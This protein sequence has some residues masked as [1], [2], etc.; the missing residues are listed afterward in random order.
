MITRIPLYRALFDEQEK[1]LLQSAHF[2][3]SAWV[4]PSGVLALGLENS[5]G[6]LVVLPYQGQM[7]WSAVFDGCDLTMTN[8]FEQPRPS[9]TVIGTYG[10]FMFHSGLLRNGC[11]APADDH[12]LHGEMPCATM[13][14][15]WLEIGEGFLRLGGEHE[16]A[17]GFGDRYRAEPC[18]TLHAGSALFDIAMNV[19]NLA[20]KP[21]DLM[22]MAHMNYA[23]VEDAR[24]VEP[25]GM[26][27]LRLRSSVP[28]HVKPTPAWSAYMAQLA[29]HPGQLATL[30]QPELYDPEIVF[31]FDDV[32]T[33]A[34]GQAHF[35]LEHPNGAAFYTRYRPEQFEHAARWIL[36][37]PDQQVAAFV[38]PSTCEPE[39]YAAEMAKGNVRSLAAG[40]SAAFS[41]TTGY[42]S[43]PERRALLG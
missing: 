18:V 8:L 35:L 2:K 13:D 37:N 20:G 40:A 23:Y 15:A 41:V 38:L 26:Q 11:P 4:Y 27:R 22:Y 33:D 21:M 34:Q 28:D 1:V 24:L 5:R 9:P 29:E 30:D 42:L 39:G 6:R 25:F 32:G 16:Y 31:F 17:Q 10:C 19:R 43:A 3:V 7:I 12:A 36:Y 14:S